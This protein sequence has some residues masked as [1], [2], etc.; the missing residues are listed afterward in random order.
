MSE[1]FN[2]DLLQIARQVRGMSQTAL[3]REAKLTQ[4]YLSKLENG[5]TEPT[6]EALDKIAE[7]LRFPVSFFTQSDRIY[8]LPLS[9]HPMFRKKASVAQKNLDK[10]QAELNIRLLHIRR[11]MQVTDFDAQFELPEIMLE[12]VAGGPAEVAEMVRRMWLLPNGP[13]RNLTECVERAGCLVIHCDFDGQQID[14]V[15]L[16]T[17]NLP[18]CIFLNKNQPGD[19]LRFTLAHELGHIIMHKV[20]SPEMEQEAN[21]FASTLMLPPKEIKPIISGRLTLE[22]LAAQKPVWGMSMAALLVAAKQTKAITDNQSQYLWRQMSKAGYRRREPAELDI[23]LEQPTVMPEILR[24]HMEELGYNFS[25]LQQIMHIFEDDY[26]RFYCV[27]KKKEKRAH[28]RV[29]K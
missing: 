10:L 26:N 9:V 19:R 5:L 18:P 20:P 7:V 12:D 14:G 1:S 6:E 17:P 16:K 23:P 27:E 29:V 28:L 25:E 4:G 3:S 21:A 13:V 22:R 15:T 8:G 11:L 24:L 2:S